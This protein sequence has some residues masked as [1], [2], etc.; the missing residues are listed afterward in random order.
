MKDTEKVTY[1][2]SLTGCS[3]EAI[4]EALESSDY[5]VEKAIEYLREQARMKG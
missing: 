2:R 4:I 3:Y 1:I 5:D